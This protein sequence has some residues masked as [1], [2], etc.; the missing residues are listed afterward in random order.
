[1]SVINGV[2]MISRCQTDL[3]NPYWL[4]R[5]HGL[6]KIEKY[7]FGFMLLMF[8]VAESDIN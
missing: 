4:D 8:L 2:E 1:M 7:R 5:E 6:A 3:T